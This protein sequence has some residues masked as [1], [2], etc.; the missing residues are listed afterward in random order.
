M[1]KLTYYP[2]GSSRI[3]HKYFETR[4]DAFEF[5]FKMPSGTLIELEYE[6]RNYNRPAFRSS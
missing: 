4:E 3:E 2:D 5:L 6:S 1:F